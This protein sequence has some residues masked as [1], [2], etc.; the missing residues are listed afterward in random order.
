MAQ[1]DGES[2]FRP[3]IGDLPGEYHSVITTFVKLIQ[4]CWA[5]ETDVRPTARRVQR[6]IR[7]LNPFQS[8]LYPLYSY[9]C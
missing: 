7:R 3:M 2:Y 9:Y 1:A 4:I 6:L 8:V 5:E